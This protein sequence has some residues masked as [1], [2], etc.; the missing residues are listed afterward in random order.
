MQRRSGGCQPKRGAETQR[1]ASVESDAGAQQDTPT[2]ST[3]QPIGREAPWAWPR[4]VRR[5]AQPI[6][7]GLALGA[8]YALASCGLGIIFG[9]FG[10]INF[11]HTQ[12]TTQS[13][14]TAA[15]GSPDQED[16]AK[17]RLVIRPTAVT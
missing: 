9:L 14:W 4:R 12:Y 3:D 1:E 2:G 8:I 6:T 10:V 13:S 5:T 7:S 17:V 15:F 11:A 16:I